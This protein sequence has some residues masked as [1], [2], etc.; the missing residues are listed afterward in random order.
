MASICVV[1]P[2]FV[3]YNPILCRATHLDS[4]SVSL[5]VDKVAHELPP[6]L[7]GQ[8]AVAVLGPILPVALEPILG[9][10]SDRNLRTKLN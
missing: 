1:R 5:V 2:N 7:P 4:E 9:I 6:V 8:G 10:R 3:S